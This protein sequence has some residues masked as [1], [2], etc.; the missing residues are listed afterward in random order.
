MNEYEPL[1]DEEL[2]GLARSPI[3]EYDELRLT[4][5]QV[6][7]LAAEIR[8]R[9]GEAEDAIEH[10]LITAQYI[11]KLEADNAELRAVIASA[12]VSLKGDGDG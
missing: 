12:D 6:N 3:W 10:A 5:T 1:T 9:R 7:S 4:G 11:G 2:N 8:W